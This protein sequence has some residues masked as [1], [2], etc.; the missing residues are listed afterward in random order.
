MITPRHT[1]RTAAG[2]LRFLIRCVACSEFGVSRKTFPLCRNCMNELTPA[3]ELCPRCSSPLCPQSAQPAEC[4]RPWIRNAPEDGIGSYRALYYLT[5]ACHS[6][7]KKWK[8]RGAPLFDRKILVPDDSLISKLRSLNAAAIVPIPQRDD[9]IWS[10]GRSSTETIARWLATLL[11]LPVLHALDPPGSAPRY[12]QAEL[13]RLDRYQNRIDFEIGREQPPRGEPLI[14]VDDFMTTGH[15]L[16]AAS[17]LLWRNGSGLIHVFCLGV[18]PWSTQPESRRDLMK[19]V[20]RPV[21][22]GQEREI[23]DRGDASG[24]G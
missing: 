3:P 18:R 1:F 24:L 5:D 8:T 17:R 4:L 15:T 2:M 14:L 13:K 9:R 23:P 21:T 7:L 6:L 12:R 19:S 10:L 20:R 11:E 22:V 16:R